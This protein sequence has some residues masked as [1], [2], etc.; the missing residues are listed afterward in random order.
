MIFPI[1]SIVLFFASQFFQFSLSKVIKHIEI[2]PKGQV[3]HSIQGNSPN[4][5]VRNGDI[6]KVHLPS[7]DYYPSTGNNNK[8]LCVMVIPGGGYR[9]LGEST[10]SPI[11]IWL[12]SLNISAFV[13]KHR[14]C[15]YKFPS[16]LQ[17]GLRAV[18][19]IRQKYNNSCHSIGVI[20]FSAGGHAAA[21]IGTKHSDSSLNLWGRAA[22]DVDSISAR[23][24]FMALIYPVISM[25]K[26]VTHSGSRDCYIGKHPNESMV[27]NTSANL[28]VDANTPTA[29]ILHSGNDDVVQ[30]RNSLLMY[31]SLRRQ[32]IPTEML[33]IPMGGHG[34][35]LG[36]HKETPKRVSKWRVT[37]KHYLANFMEK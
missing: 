22:D 5:E 18:R 16:H 10:G 35:D 28:L 19:I 30:E 27:T 36:F 31:E 21:M 1:C 15:E 6:I 2:W 17:D 34:Y 20:G 12:N 33:L 9:L 32:N 3:P 11:A 24:D 8:K 13:L 25:D 4:Y 26:N 37:F 14:L 23:P 7:I 29:F